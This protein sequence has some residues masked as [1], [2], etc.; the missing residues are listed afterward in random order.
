M[1]KYRNQYLLFSV[2]PGPVLHRNRYFLLYLVRYFTGNGI[3]CY[4]WSGTSQE[5][6]FS[7]IPGPVLYRNQY[8]LLYL[9]WYFTGTGIFCYTWSGTLQ[10][11]VFSVIPGPAVSMD[12]IN[13]I[14]T[15]SVQ[16]S[17]L[18]VII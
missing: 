9:V 7:V 10:E 12:N 13:K 18:T 5:P 11:P 2:I 15:V 4:T 1:T 16:S 6:V 14:C 8:F 17:L 3:F